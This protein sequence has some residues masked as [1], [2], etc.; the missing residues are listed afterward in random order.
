MV[1]SWK[2]LRLQHPMKN[3]PYSRAAVG[4]PKMKEMASLAEF[5]NP[6]KLYNPHMTVSMG[7]TKGE[8][9]RGNL[10]IS[11]VTDKLRMQS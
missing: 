7:L 2:K 4:W 1:F 5:Y 11:W 3:P 10:L 6:E 9:S 8:I